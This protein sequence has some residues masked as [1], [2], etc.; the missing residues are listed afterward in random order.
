M[1]PNKQLVKRLKD[2]G[3]KLLP[4]SKT[5]VMRMVIKSSTSNR[6]YLVSKRITALTRWECS[7]PGWILKGQRK[8]KH[9]EAMA[10]ILDLTKQLPFAETK[11]LEYKKVSNAKKRT[12]T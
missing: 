7:C 11:R 5:H 9:I 2:F 8:C 3:V 10:P 1:D 6:K 4:D 12:K